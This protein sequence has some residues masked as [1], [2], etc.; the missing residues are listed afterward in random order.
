TVGIFVMVALQWRPVNAR[1]GTLVLSR[2]PFRL[3]REKRGNAVPHGLLVFG[4][5]RTHPGLGKQG[6]KFSC[7]ARFGR[8]R[9]YVLVPGHCKYAFSKREQVQVWQLGHGLCHRS[10]P[11]WISIP[12]S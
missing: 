9:A 5:T 6:R 12:G 3:K 7:G 11:Y 10:P 4:G 1:A 2:L 8:D